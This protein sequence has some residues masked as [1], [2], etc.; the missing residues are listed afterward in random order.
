MNSTFRRSLV[1][2]LLLTFCNAAL[3]LVALGAVETYGGGADWPAVLIVLIAL[4]VEICVYGTTVHGPIFRW[5]EEPERVKRD[6]EARE[7]AESRRA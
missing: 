3:C 5:I 4:I 2:F 7:Y 1:G 6:A